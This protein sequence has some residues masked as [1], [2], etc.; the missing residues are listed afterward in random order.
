MAFITYRAS[1]TPTLPTTQPAVKATPLTNLEVDANFKALDEAK[2]EKTGSADS[3]TGVRLTAA[4]GV[5]GILPVA[6]GGTGTSSPAYATTTGSGAYVLVTSPTLVTPNL[7]AVTSGNISNCTSTSM[8]L[9]TPVLGTPTSITLTNA[10]GLP[11]ASGVSGNLPAANGGTGVTSFTSDA[12]PYASSTTAL[13]TSNA[14]KYNATSKFLLVNSNSSSSPPTVIT[15]TVLDLHGVD[16]TVARIQ[17]SSYGGTADTSLAPHLTFR[18]ANGTMV[19]PTAININDSLGSLTTRSYDGTAWTAASSASLLFES[20]QA[21]SGTTHGSRIL[22]VTTANT[23]SAVAAER[24]RINNA[25]NVGIGTSSPVARLDVNGN[26]TMNIVPIAM[27]GTAANMVPIDCSLG[28][29]FQGT[30]D[31][32]TIGGGSG[33]N[34]VNFTFSNVPASRGYMFMLEIYLTSTYAASHPGTSLGWNTSG[35]TAGTIYWANGVS[36]TVT[37]NKTHI[38]TFITYDGGTTWRASGQT[39]YV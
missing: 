39:N 7:G 10:T 32:N 4:A 31:W 26:Q 8:Q 15:G 6:N 16:S 1:T 20:E 27:T 25:G 19:V 34:N 9:V 24:M 33:A 22:F 21:W 5:T 17:I 28:N 2:L 18:R 38:F 30:F 12:I 13:T 29:Y 37:N 14:L 11:L 36:P 23:T 3:L 35:G